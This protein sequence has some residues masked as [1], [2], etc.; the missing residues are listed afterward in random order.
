[1]EVLADVE[2][3][4]LLGFGIN[5]LI[6]SWKIS[7]LWTAKATRLP[8]RIHQ[9]PESGLLLWSQGLTAQSRQYKSLKLLI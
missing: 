1:M 2:E 5:I 9:L 7:P 8:N 4:I 6:D 3:K